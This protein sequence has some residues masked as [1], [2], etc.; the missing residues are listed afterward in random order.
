MD[1]II[2]I[3]P[4]TVFISGK[5]L[6]EDDALGAVNNVLADLYATS[7]LSNVDTAIDTLLGIQRFSGKSLAML[8]HG[9]SAWW[10]ESRTEYSFKDHMESRHG[11]KG[12]TI[13]RYITVWECVSSGQ[14]PEDVA[15]RPMRELVPIAKT[16]SHG[17]T[18]DQK[19]W[20]KIVKANGL[21]EIGDILRN[22]KGKKARKSSMQITWQ[23]D[24][25]LNAWK[26]NKKHFLGW[27]DKEAYE[28]DP[29][30]RK[31]IDRILDSS[32][33]IRK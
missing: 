26:D 29:D 20:N 8:L 5:A 28:S 19:Q 6:T 24:G 32:G 10:Q 2:A 25:S 22:V 12:V 21:G 30:A 9:T 27:L 16:I 23:R 3:S 7:N 15:V 14:I 33:I 18:I 4:D 13:D 17:Y 31:A 1:E 11:L